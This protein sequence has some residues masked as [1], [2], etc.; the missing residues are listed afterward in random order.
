MRAVGL[1]E[2]YDESLLILRH[3]LNLPDWEVAYGNPRNVGEDDQAFTD[4]PELLERHRDDILQ[5]NS[6]DI[7]LYEFVRDEVWPSQVADYGGSQKLEKDLETTLA[8]AG[9]QKKPSRKY[10]WQVGTNRA[11]R[12]LAYKPLVT[13]DCVRKR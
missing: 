8:H 3:R 13:L 10:L 9:E 1:V 4:L 12:N 11:Y 7:L 2:R 5:R 6:L